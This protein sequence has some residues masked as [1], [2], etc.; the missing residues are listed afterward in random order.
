MH[1]VGIH[2]ADEETC[3]IGT[4]LLALMDMKDTSATHADS[5]YDRAVVTRLVLA[6]VAEGNSVSVFG[7]VKMANTVR[8]V[9]SGCN[10]RRE[11]TL[12]GEE[13]SRMEAEIRKLLAPTPAVDSVL[14]CAQRRPWRV[15]Q[16]DAL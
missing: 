1:G 14:I 9:H 7:L 13:L 2:V 15:A 3:E 6:E 8:L 5:V 10:T 16:F 11:R 12:C 4:K